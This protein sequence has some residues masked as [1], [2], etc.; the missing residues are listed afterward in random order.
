MEANRRAGAMNSGETG[1]SRRIH[2]VCLHC[3]PR[4]GAHN[5]AGNPRAKYSTGP[6]TASIHSPEK[7]MQI[8]RRL[9]GEAAEAPV[10]H[11]FISIHRLFR[12]G[13]FMYM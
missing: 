5:I 7:G 10:D 13:N 4:S 12:V 1:H 3:V 2:M 6:S 11:Q 8:I 9:E